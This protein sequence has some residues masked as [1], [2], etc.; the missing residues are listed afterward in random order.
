MAE[1]KRP[2]PVSM[3]RGKV[4][5]PVSI[6]LTPDHHSKVEEARKRLGGGIT[7][8]DLI[9]LLIQRHAQ[10]VERQPDAYDGLA[11]AVESLGGRLLLREHGG[12]SG[13]A[14]R[15]EL[16]SKFLM[17]RKPYALL[18]GCHRKLE[19]APAR[20]VDPVG[21]AKL[22]ETLGTEGQPV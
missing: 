3:F 11:A 16:G 21:L 5:R 19:G 18:E 15:L 13:N 10:T 7:R 1:R 20:E 6:T 17:I 22:F 14:W 9:G 12:P 8:S 2:G 4:R